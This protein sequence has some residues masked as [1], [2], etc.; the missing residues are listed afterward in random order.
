M[1]AL[2]G[3]IMRRLQAQLTPLFTSFSRIYKRLFTNSRF[4]IF[5]HTVIMANSYKG[6]IIILRIDIF[7][8]LWYNTITTSDLN[9]TQGI[10]SCWRYAIS[11]YLRSLVVIRIGCGNLTEWYV[12][13]CRSRKGTTFFYFNLLNWNVLCSTKRYFWTTKLIL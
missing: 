8:I 12:D 11:F 3:A 6:S 9:I 4:F 10:Y 5:A 2:F 7:W 13:R 1:E